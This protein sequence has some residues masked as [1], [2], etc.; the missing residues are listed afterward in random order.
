MVIPRKLLDKAK[1]GNGEAQLE[2]GRLY[3]D[4]RAGHYDLE[5]AFGWFEKASDQDLPEALL[6]VALAKEYGLGTDRDYEVAFSTYMRASRLHKGPL[7]F[8]I[9]G[10]VLT[11]NLCLDKHRG[12]LALAEAGYAHAQWSFV[13]GPKRKG[14]PTPEVNPGK[15]LK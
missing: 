2:V 7:P 10:L 8:T 9:R 15:W 14:N 6:E 1:A 13:Y 11:Q 4:G 5:E 3:A 12:Q